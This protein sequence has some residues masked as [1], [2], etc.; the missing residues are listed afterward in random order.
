[1]NDEWGYSR[2]SVYENDG[3]GQVHRLVEAGIPRERILLDRGVSGMKAAASRPEFA[4]MSAQLSA[5][6]TVVTPELSRI[7]RSVKDVLGTIESFEA[8]GIRL[9]ILDLALDTATPTGRMVV[10]VLAAVAR[11]E[12]DLC[13]QR[14]KS[15][16][17]ARKAAG[18]PLGR[19]RTITD[20][21]IRTARKLRAGNMPVGE[22][23]TT[24]D[25]PRSSLYRYLSEPA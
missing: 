25:V 4:R 1:M 10:T 14:T 16:L 21:Q 5:G 3:A 24:L 8:R 23:A 17:A 13:S 20:A 15:A 6:D 11:L 12:R 9:R 18:K 19:T 2:T 22:I 7:G